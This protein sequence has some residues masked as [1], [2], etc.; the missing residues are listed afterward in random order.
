MLYHKAVFCLLFVAEL[1]LHTL[2]S[3]EKFRMYNSKLAKNWVREYLMTRRDAGIDHSAGSKPWRYSICR[4][5]PKRFQNVK[6]KT[7]DFF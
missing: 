1:L 3:S 2:S 5:L 6:C 4:L 7:L